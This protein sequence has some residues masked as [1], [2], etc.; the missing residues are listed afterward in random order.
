MPVMRVRFPSP[1]PIFWLNYLRKKAPKNNNKNNNSRAFL[2]GS[3]GVEIPEEAI[4]GFVAPSN[5]TGKV[6]LNRKHL[7]LLAYS[8]AYRHME[9]STTI[10]KCWMIII[11]LQFTRAKI[12]QLMAGI[13]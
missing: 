6:T 7:P 3:H 13:A 12:H 4:A 2:R 9:D 10:R 1:A 8:G 5:R 11:R